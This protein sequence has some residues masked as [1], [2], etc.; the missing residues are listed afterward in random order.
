MENKKRQFPFWVHIAIGV[1]WVI[2]GATVVSGFATLLW[3]A[4]GLVL[5]TIGMLAMR[6]QKK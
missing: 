2:V 5:I 1:L 4:G 3:I 6:K